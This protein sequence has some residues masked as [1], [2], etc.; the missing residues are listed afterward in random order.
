MGYCCIYFSFSFQ[1]SATFKP[2][3]FSL[4]SSL[5]FATHPVLTEAVNAI[6]FRED[7]LCFLFFISAL[8]PY[9]VHRSLLIAHCSKF[10]AFCFQLL[11]LS[12]YL[13]A[14]LSK[15][16]AI[17]FPLIIILYEWV[18]GGKIELH[19]KSPPLHKGRVRVA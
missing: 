9:I 18:Y 6:S 11:S 8:I 10:K 16:M 14:L 1:P 17:T 5:L 13:L 4:F 15:E 12:F 19:P 2:L 3:Y 7:G